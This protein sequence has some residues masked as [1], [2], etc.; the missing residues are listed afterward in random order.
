MK[1][2]KHTIYI[3]LALLLTNCVQEKHKKTIH[4][5]LDM[6]GVDN[7]KNVGVRGQFTS[8]SWEKT[9]YLNDT[10]NDSVFE[11]SITREAAQYGFQFKFVNQDSIYELKNQSNRTVLLQYKPETLLYEAIFNNPNGTTSTLK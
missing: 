2:I 1:V 11:G 3:V 7:I 5:K 8:P 9:I 4:F 10:N 6:R